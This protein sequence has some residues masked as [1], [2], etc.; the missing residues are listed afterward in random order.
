MVVV[1]VAAR[2]VPAQTGGIGAAQVRRFVEH[3]ACNAAAGMAE[4]SRTPLPCAG[5]HL[6]CSAAEDRHPPRSQHDVAGA[7]T[8]A[9]SIAKDHSCEHFAIC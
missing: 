3:F 5:L 9:R 4:V 6:L 7:S 2:V 1:N 8:K